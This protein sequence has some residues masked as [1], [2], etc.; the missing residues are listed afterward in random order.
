M[1]TREIGQ[2]ENLKQYILVSGFPSLLSRC[3][4]LVSATYFWL[5]IFTVVHPLPLFPSPPG[6]PVSVSELAVEFSWQQ[7]FAENTSYNLS[8]SGSTVRYPHELGPPVDNGPRL[9]AGH[10]WTRQGCLFF[11]PVHIYIAR[12]WRSRLLAQRAFPRSWSR[13]NRSRWPS[14]LPHGPVL[15]VRVKLLFFLHLFIYTSQYHLPAFRL[16]N[17]GLW[18]TGSRMW[19]ITYTPH[20]IAKLSGFFCCFQLLT[21]FPLAILSVFCASNLLKITVQ[22]LVL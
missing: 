8:V 3:G 19:G 12:D 1:T 14:E 9:R 20:K 21:A 16:S 22:H 15:A 11:T 13:A 6:L 7:L 2:G 5:F 18:V 17:S 4:R 10:F